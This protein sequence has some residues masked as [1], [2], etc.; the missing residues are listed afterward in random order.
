MAFVS[1]EQRKAVMAKLRGA[2]GSKPVAISTEIKPEEQV[3]RDIKYISDTD[4][5][6]G[7]EEVPHLF[8]DRHH[9]ENL[10][11]DA[12]LRGTGGVI[13]RKRVDLP[14]AT[15]SYYEKF[16]YIHPM[17]KDPKV[18]AKFSEVVKEGGI[19]KKVGN[20]FV[21][22]RPTEV[23]TI[24]EA[25][26][27]ENIPKDTVVDILRNA[28]ELPDEIHEIGGDTSVGIAPT[29][30][31]FHDGV[32]YSNLRALPIKKSKVIQWRDD[33]EK[34]EDYV[35]KGDFSPRRS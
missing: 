16:P 21:E 27:G 30:V 18:R 12:A 13:D 1:N 22:L 10:E 5:V 20:T 19:I 11:I 14:M 6:M 26:N 31:V 25:S 7:P 15:K 35:S 29:D 34:S 17:E 28:V 23:S 3:I 24:I 2:L 9:I 32:Y 8:E 33:D 4:I